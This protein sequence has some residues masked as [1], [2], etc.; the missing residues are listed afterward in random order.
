MQLL[1]SLLYISSTWLVFVQGLHVEKLHQDSSW[2]LINGNATVAVPNISALNTHL[3]LI[4][5]GVLQGNPYYRDNELRWGWVALDTWKYATSWKSTSEMLSHSDTVIRCQIDTVAMVK[6][7]GVLVGN[8]TSMHQTYDFDARHL[9]RPLGHDNHIEVI[10]LPAMEYALTEAKK[11]PYPVPESVYYGTWTE[12][13][14]P[15]NEGWGNGTYTHRNF[16]RKIASDFGW[17]WG[18]AFVPSGI[19]QFEVV[20]RHVAT[21]DTVT[22]NQ[23]HNNNNSVTLLVNAHVDAVLAGNVQLT[24]GVSQGVSLKQ[25]STR[26]F[27]VKVGENLLK[28]EL[29]IV[30]PKLW[31]PVGHGEA[32]LYDLEVKLDASKPSIADMNAERSKI[33]KKIG[34]R[35]VELVTD[36]LPGGHSFFFRINGVDIYAKGSNFIPADVFQPRAEKDLEWILRS[37][38]DANMNMVRVWGGGMYQVD[39]FYDMADKMGIM[40]KLVRILYNNTGIVSS[41]TIASN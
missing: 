17:D 31:W 27:D 34:L 30:D 21:L 29:E 12:G 35:T 14:Q 33:S 37:A 18:P 41:I 10:I 15:D 24:S 7:N 2:D 5:D 39:K 6:V 20:S 32:Y 8:T 28:I 16:V 3:A 26:L 9:L 23:R 11:Y 38:V 13:S 40:S 1:A 19:M 36:P 25:T 4:E 22:V